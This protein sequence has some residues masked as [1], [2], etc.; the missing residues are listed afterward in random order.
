[1]DCIQKGYEKK[2][3]CVCVLLWIFGFFLSGENIVIYWQVKVVCCMIFGAVSFSWTHWSYV[4]EV[5]NF[6]LGVLCYRTVFV[7]FF[8][9]KNS[10]YF[11]KSK[12]TVCLSIRFRD[13][14]FC[15]STLRESNSSSLHFVLVMSCCFMP[16]LF[17][18]V[19]WCCNWVCMSL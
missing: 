1:M 8:P 5:N 18:K 9:F 10:Q 17:R 11:G 4:S 2:I 6:M 7:F 13:L 19:S 3:C 14:S 16:L 15:L 12:S